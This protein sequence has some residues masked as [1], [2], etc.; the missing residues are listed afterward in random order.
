MR[1]NVDK[2]QILFQKNKKIFFIENQPSENTHELINSTIEEKEKVYLFSSGNKAD[3]LYEKKIVN[4]TNFNYFQIYDEKFYQSLQ[5]I[6]KLLNQACDKYQINKE[7]NIYYI[8]SSYE[9]NFS[10]DFWYDF[11]GIKIPVF[12]GY[13]FIDVENESSISIDGE[14]VKIENGTIILF[15]PGHKLSF[16]GVNAAISFNLSTLSK[17]KNHYPQKWMPI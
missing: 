2:E 14:N 17:I 4:K 11:G 15:E 13:W 1:K 16:N 7:K 12:C 5:K 8:A 10:S 3:F 9:N 6:K